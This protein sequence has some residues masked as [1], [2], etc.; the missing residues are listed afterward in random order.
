MLTAEGVSPVFLGLLRA[1]PLATMTVLDVGTGSGRLA[2]ALALHCRRVVGIDR[3][4]GLIDEARRRAQ[5][6]GFGNIE[7]A[8]ADAERVEFSDIVP[9]S[10][11]VRPDMVTAHLYLSDTLVA[12]ASKALRRGGVLAFLGFHADQWRETGRRSR[13]AYDEEQVKRLLEACDFTLE[14]LE[15]E[16]DV[17]TFDSVEAA[18][19]AVVTLEDRWRQD[20]RWFR[21]VAYLEEGGRQLTRAALVVKARRR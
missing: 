10:L 1:E 7:F 12:G 21:Y 3:D 16:R 2:L 20:G 19:A 14:H 11:H 5:A 15:V 6:A 13:F 18:L 9:G 17:R 4:P 8:V